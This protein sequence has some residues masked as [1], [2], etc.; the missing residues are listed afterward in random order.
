MCDFKDV[1]GKIDSMV[2][3]ME[4]KMGTSYTVGYLMAMY[5]IALVD[6]KNV[7]PVFFDLNMKSIDTKLKEFENEK[8]TASVL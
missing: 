6:L 1:H 3:S 5:A 7:S 8:G 4:K 2:T